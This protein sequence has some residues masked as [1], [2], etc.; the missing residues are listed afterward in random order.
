MLHHN[1]VQ[2]C[3]FPDVP[4]HWKKITETDSPEEDNGFKDPFD[5]ERGFIHDIKKLRQ[6]FKFLKSKHARNI[7]DVVE[8]NY[9]FIKCD[10]KASMD[11]TFYNVKIA[12]SIPSGNVKLCQC[13]CKAQSLR[14][15][16]HISGLL[17]YIWCHVRINGNEGKLSLVFLTHG[18]ISRVH[19]QYFS[20][21][22]YGNAI[23]YCISAVHLRKV[24]RRFGP[25][26]HPSSNL[27]F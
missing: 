1:F 12:I 18:F 8:N 13:E 21:C 6:G 4:D 26:L 7:Q 25:H 9:Y 3:L 16:C 24:C 2:F 14:R 23:T 20:F 17:L 11:Q 22:F 5:E 19:H 15:C 27:P 10:M